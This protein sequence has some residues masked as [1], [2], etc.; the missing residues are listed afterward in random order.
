MSKSK[1]LFLV[2]RIGLIIFIL[3]ISVF[4]Q[5]KSIIIGTGVQSGIITPFEN[6]IYYSTTQSIY[7][8]EEI[9]YS[10]SITSLSFYVSKNSSYKTNSV[11]IYLGHKTNNIF[12]N[13]EDYLSLDQLTEVY[14][15]SPTLGAMQGWEEFKFHTPFEYDGKNNLVVVV[16]KQ[17]KTINQNL[18]YQY[19]YYS[20]EKINLS[21]TSM[22]EPELGTLSGTGEYNAWS[23]RANVKLVFDGIDDSG[24]T[25]WTDTE[26]SDCCIDGIHYR[27]DTTYLLATVIKES[28]NASNY[29]NFPSD[30]LTIPSVVY[31]KNTMFIVRYIDEYAFAYNTTIKKIVLGNNIMEIGDHAF[32]SN[33]GLTNINIPGLVKNIPAHAFQG[34]SN[35]AILDIEEGKT[36]LTLNH[37]ELYNV[38]LNRYDYYG[39]FENCPL[40][41]VNIKRQIVYSLPNLNSTIRWYEGAPFG[42]STTL[43]SVVL[44]ENVTSIDKYMFYN[45]S[46]LQNVQI[47]GNNLTIVDDYAFCHCERIKSL[48]F[49]ENT[50]TFGIQSLRGLS[51][52]PLIFLAKNMDCR[53]KF[54]WQSGNSVIWA[55]NSELESIKAVAYSNLNHL[56][57][58]DNP[59]V[60]KTTSY[61]KAITFSISF[62]EYF[63]IPGATIQN[64][65]YNGALLTHDGDGYYKLSDLEIA[66]DYYIDVKYTLDASNP[67]RTQHL[68]ISTLTPTITISCNNS[69]RTQTT[70]GISCQASSDETGTWTERGIFYS[71][72][73]HIGNKNGKVVIKKL[74][75]NTTYDIRGYAMYND[76]I[77][78]SESETFQTKAIELD[79]ETEIGPT[80]I[81]CHG[82][83]E[84]GDVNIV[85]CGYIVNNNN[86]TEGTVLTGLDPDTDH[87]VSYY[88]RSE[89]GHTT[90]I[91]KTIRTQGIKLTTLPPKGVSSTCSIVTATT[92]ISENETKAGF[93]WKKYD[94]PTSL[95]PNEGYAAIYKEQLEGRIQNLQ[96]TFYYNVR[97]FYKSA[98]GNYYYGDWVTFDPSDFSYFEPTVHT[99]E[100]TKVGNNSAIVTG[101][102]LAGTE[103]IMEQ[104]FE[105]WTTDT[106]ESKLI[107]IKT[108]EEN[109]VSTVV[110]T[111]QMMTATLTN[112]QPNTTYF[113]RSFVKTVS[114]TTYGEEQTFITNTSTGIGNIE[115]NAYDIVVI[116]GYYDLSGRKYNELQK[117]INIIRYSDGT[118]QKIIIK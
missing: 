96:P 101:Y 92:N 73:K 31:Y 98:A 44:G 11:K 67:N 16:C 34:C 89:S 59:I 91:T 66:E 21:R 90:S 83:Y 84:N 62:G 77:F 81:C 41:S 18:E 74:D 118:T 6:S 78:Y 64:I 69:D 117:G 93:Q 106:K 54:L 97:A 82:I 80:S 107:C 104:G 53:D 5:A 108:M 55:Y 12:L 47:I 51:A 100:A 19:T 22:T 105:Y 26:T 110:S 111:G 48:C 40:D 39:T 52:K 3:L 58:I 36:S 113:F 23:W 94:A 112:L 46:N 115:V 79:F 29:S 76:K 95:A 9:G 1:Y 56:Y 49:P 65:T 114:G 71:G 103:D 15:G 35:L 10:G 87:E 102:V 37:R 20:G 116:T 38:K 63:F 30:Q 42:Q 7:T 27:L 32:Y 4:I 99:Y 88:V 109:N 14:S 75:P 28:D 72:E 68:K 8:S 50:K 86:Y 70:L 43:R 45:C 57:D 2:Q 60:A 17:A 61:L 85:E 25:G 24:D 13:K 33:T